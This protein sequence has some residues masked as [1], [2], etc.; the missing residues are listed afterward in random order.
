MSEKPP[1]SVEDALRAITA[2]RKPIL[3]TLA[4]ERLADL[5]HSAVVLVVVVALGIGA[6]ALI[7]RVLESGMLSYFIH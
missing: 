7:R 4:V 1:A 5:L 6:M 2:V 3:P